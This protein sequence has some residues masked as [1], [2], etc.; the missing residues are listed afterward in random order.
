MNN[1][2]DQLVLTRS[3]GDKV[4]INVNNVNYITST[5]HMGQLST[6]INFAGSSQVSLMVTETFEEVSKKLEHL[7]E[8]S[9]QY[10]N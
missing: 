10:E 8:V 2:K 7:K 3:S 4:I 6:E 9:L 5:E 1:I